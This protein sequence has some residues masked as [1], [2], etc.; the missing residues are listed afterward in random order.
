MTKGAG[1][2]GEGKGSGRRSSKDTAMSDDGR[3]RAGF[4]LAIS[5]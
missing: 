4:V 1:P 3:R 2:C 5:G